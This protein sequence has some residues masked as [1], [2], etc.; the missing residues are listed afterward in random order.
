[1]HSISDITCLGM[2]VMMLTKLKFMVTPYEVFFSCNL[3]IY[4]YLLFI[5]SLPCTFVYEATK[6]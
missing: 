5:Y 6:Q 4:Y 2:R 3:F 1:M